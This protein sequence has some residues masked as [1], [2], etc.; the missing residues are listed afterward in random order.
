MPAA[1]EAAIVNVRA[2]DTGNVLA[3]KMV[4]AFTCKVAER[5]ATMAER[6]IMVL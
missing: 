2:D 5:R 1:V 4:K 3:G 6:E